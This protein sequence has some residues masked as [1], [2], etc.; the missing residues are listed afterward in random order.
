MK[1]RESQLFVKF[2]GILSL[3]YFFPFRKHCLLNTACTFLLWCAPEG[4]ELPTR[5]RRGLNG[6]NST[7]PT[8]AGLATWIYVPIRSAAAW[9]LL[10]LNFWCFHP[11]WFLQPFYISPIKF[12]ACLPQNVWSSFW[13]SG[14]RHLPH[15]L[16]KDINCSIICNTLKY[17]HLLKSKCDW[18]GTC[19]MAMRIL[20]LLFQAD[21]NLTPFLLC[22]DLEY[23]TETTSL[24]L[25][26]Q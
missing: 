22:L 9:Q 4:E 8:L 24:S 6:K 25:Q 16:R 7:L 11:G 2:G 1:D 12:N 23:T 13:C 3:E 17:L 26:Q 21:N 15:R 18:Q 19:W 20:S 10:T 14:K 5:I